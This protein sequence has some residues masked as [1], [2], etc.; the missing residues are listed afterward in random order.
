MERLAQKSTRFPSPLVRTANEFKTTKLGN[1]ETIWPFYIPPWQKEAKIII[2]EKDDAIREAISPRRG[3]QW[4]TDG[5]SRNN[6]AGI[7]LACLTGAPEPWTYHE[8][9]GRSK[10]MTTPYIELAAVERA[11]DLTNKTATLLA[12]VSVTIFSDSQDILRALASTNQKSGQQLLRKCLE[13]IQILEQKWSIRV[14][15]R[16]V[17]GH[18]GVQGNEI[19]HAQAIQATEKGPPI[20]STV[21]LKT[22]ALQVARQRLQLKTHEERQPNRHIW[23]IDKATS[24]KH[25]KGLYNRLTARDAAILVQLRTGRCRLNQY[26]SRIKAAPSPDCETCQKPETVEHFILQCKR[27][28]GQRQTLARSAGEHA[29]NLAP[30]LGGWDNAR[31][32]QGKWKYGPPEKWRPDHKLVSATIAFTKSTGRLD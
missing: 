23:K 14:S 12:G 27:W 15:L 20:R 29:A 30:L 7:G 17:P 24:G 16:W 26:L 11:L 4:Y 8:T 21:K 19:A 5:S 3:V 10:D 32:R 1:L 31:N 18:S 28:Q 25:L 2:Q 13:R 22:K 6:R 9:I